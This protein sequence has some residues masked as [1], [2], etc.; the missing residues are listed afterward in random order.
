MGSVHASKYRTMEGVRTAAY[1]T[2]AERLAAFCARF[3]ADAAPSA[4]SLVADSD[5]VDVCL[6]TPLHAAAA[7]LALGAGKPT[8]VEKPLGRTLEDCAR[9]SEAARESGA[10]LMPAQVVRWFREHRAVHD[11]V[12]RGEVGTPAA[13][14]LRRGGG[15]PKGEWFLDFEASGG[16]LLDLAVHDFD[17]LLWTLGPAVSVHAQSVRLGAGRPA[18][19]FRGDGALTVVK[20]ASGAVAHVENTWM[21]PSGFR[22][23]IE[24]AGSDG[25]IEFDSRTNPSLRV[26]GPQGQRAE[27]NYLPE[28]DPYHGQL[29]AF[30]ESART[31]SPPPVTA[32]EGSAAVRLALAAIESAQTGMTVAVPSG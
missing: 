9:M 19:R 10:M 23:A 12:V 26:A 21:D 4:E 16:I 2:D 30:L 1:D 31:G 18:A 27:N 28:D 20:F 11:A 5:A 6:P 29:S 15:P 32:D 13:V 22:T 8:L 17:W 14:R 24:V 25:L 3:E 7:C